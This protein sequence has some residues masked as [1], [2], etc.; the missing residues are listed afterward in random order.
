MQERVFLK[1]HLASPDAPDR[2]QTSI[3]AEI[4]RSM[5]RQIWIEASIAFVATLSLVSYL[6]W[7]WQTI[8][9]DLQESS[10]VPL[11]RLVIS[12]PDILFS[13]VQETA[14]SLIET[15]PVQSILLG[16]GII[17]CLTCTIGFS[18]RLREV[19]HHLSPQL[20]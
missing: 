19:R 17:L 8:W 2:L 15:A 11:A 13:N 7:S 5:L 16:L 6:V 18:L 9:L 12:D 14:W 1:A 10:F 3:M 20:T 4:E